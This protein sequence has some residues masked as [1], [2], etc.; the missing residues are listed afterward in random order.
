[1]AAAEFLKEEKSFV[2][3]GADLSGK[4]GLKAKYIFYLFYP[5]H[6][7]I[8]YCFVNFVLYKNP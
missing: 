8:I 2:I 6:I 1:M 5:L 3:R 4:R 7:Y